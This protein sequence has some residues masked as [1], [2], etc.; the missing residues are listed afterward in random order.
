MRIA[1]YTDLLHY[2][3][4]L[5]QAK[6]IDMLLCVMGTSFTP[7]S[8][9]SLMH[10]SVDPSPPAGG[11]PTLTTHVH[12]QAIGTL[13]P[14]DGVSSTLHE[15]AHV[16]AIRIIGA[17]VDLLVIS[18]SLVLTQT[19]F[20]RAYSRIIGTKSF[21]NANARDNSKNA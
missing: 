7:V 10:C 1:H 4:P 18:T 13:G 12:S 20:F 14:D 19:M 15:E 8:C 3:P 17:F 2:V 9:Y 11:R 16:K 6:G 5:L 21:G